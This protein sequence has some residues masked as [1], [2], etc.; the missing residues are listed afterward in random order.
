MVVG[1]VVVVLVSVWIVPR[2]F[3]VALWQ[4]DCW[5]PDTV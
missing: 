4:Q 2:T 5:I 3:V 1:E